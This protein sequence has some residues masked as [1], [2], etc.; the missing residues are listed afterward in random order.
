MLLKSF[1]DWGFAYIESNREAY[2][3]PLSYTECK[4]SDLE[5]WDVFI[6]EEYA[7]NPKLQNFWIFMW[8]NK[9]W[10]YIGQHL[11]DNGWIETIAY[12]N[13]YSTNYDVIKINRF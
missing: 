13:Y 8:K 12:N 2:K 10:Y 5:K 9:S 3:D 1:A 11:D 4:L 6:L 7:K